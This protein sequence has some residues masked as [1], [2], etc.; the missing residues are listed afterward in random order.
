MDKSAFERRIRRQLGIHPA[1]AA[2][3]LAMP[4]EVLEAQRAA[5]PLIEVE[6][7]GTDAAFAF[8]AGTGP[9]FINYSRLCKAWGVDAANA[10]L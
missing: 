8:L 7:I 1:L 9:G 6:E 2:A 3:E 4:A 5:L 10:C